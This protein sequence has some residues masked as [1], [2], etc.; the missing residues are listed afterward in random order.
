MVRDILGNVFS[1]IGLELMA[2]P[3]SVIFKAI[4]NYLILT[5]SHQIEYILF[6][7]FV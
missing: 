4:I 7:K 5:L 1:P 6:I 2:V 3:M